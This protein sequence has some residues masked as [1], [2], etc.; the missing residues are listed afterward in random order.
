MRIS[1]GK[2]VGG[3]FYPESLR[4]VE[5]FETPVDEPE[6]P[7]LAAFTELVE[8]GIDQAEVEANAETYSALTAPLDIVHI[9]ARAPA[10]DDA[11][12]AD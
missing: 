8:R 6:L 3:W 10:R 7:G 9:P 11:E 5:E 4:S 2:L 1:D 12:A